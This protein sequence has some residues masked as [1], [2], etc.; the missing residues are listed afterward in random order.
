M[1]DLPVYHG[2]INLGDGPTAFLSATKTSPYEMIHPGENIGPFKLL[3]VNEKEIELQWHG[4]TIH[5]TA[6]ELMDTSQTAAAGQASPA[7]DAR[8]VAPPAVAAVAQEPPSEKG[9][10]PV[11]QFNTASCQP[12]DTTPVGTVRDGMRKT[13]RVTPFGTV[14][15]WE[16]V[17]AR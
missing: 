1:P 3:S 6:E 2:I 13:Q 16:S 5:K 10:G 14:C 11:N 12:N 17:G 9:P 4:K 8:S 15:L 7:G